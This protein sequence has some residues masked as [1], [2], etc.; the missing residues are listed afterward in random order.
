MK[1]LLVI[2]VLAAGGYGIYWWLEQYAG[3]AVTE[4]TSGQVERGQEAVEKART[5]AAGAAVQ[6]VRSAVEA[7]RAATGSW[8][9]SL[10]E[11][12]DKGYLQN[13]PGGINYD[14]ATGTV[15]AAQ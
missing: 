7:Y 5:V 3:K 14:P 2:A 12:V 13:V 9:A 1:K 10:Q 4:A 11:L 6:A 8:P 15:S